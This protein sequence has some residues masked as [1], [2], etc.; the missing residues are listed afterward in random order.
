MNA[1]REQLY[2]QLR[3]WNII[4]ARAEVRIGQL[5][6]WTWPRS[7]AQLWKARELTVEE[8][9]QFRLAK[10]L[11]EFAWREARAIQTQL[12]RKRESKS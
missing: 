6:P 10:N 4:R 7:G 12:W 1:P 2:A 9:R 5:W 3:R 8:S 11:S